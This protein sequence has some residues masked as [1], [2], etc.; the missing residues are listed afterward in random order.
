MYEPDTADFETYQRVR[1]WIDT[2]RAAWKS[3]GLTQR[4][5]L[6]A[7]V[8]SRVPLN[9]NRDWYHA[10]SDYE[11]GYFFAAAALVEDY[12]AKD[13]AT[14]LVYPILFLYR[15]YVELKLK[16]IL[17][18][19]AASLPGNVPEK[20]GDEHNLLNLW[21]MLLDLLTQYGKSKML[22]GS[23]STERILAQLTQIDPVSMETRYALQKDLKT[24]TLDQL[25]SVDLQNFGGVMAKLH[26]E[27]N[28]IEVLFQY[29]HECW[30]DE[31]PIASISDTQ[32]EK[33]V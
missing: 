5:D 17:F 23:E 14:P 3:Q 9:A 21:K 33:K 27:L 7:V 31:G 10:W 12:G 32:T 15:H 4:D 16:S 29:V 20:A 25:R 8:A 6:R 1:E 26:S 28:K 11:W 19:A 18:E 2:R 13:E 22:Q 24:P 30:W